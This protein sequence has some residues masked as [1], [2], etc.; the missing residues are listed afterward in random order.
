MSLELEI[1]R[2]QAFFWLFSTICQDPQ[3]VSVKKVHS[4]FT[5]RMTSVDFSK[6]WVHKI[7]TLLPIF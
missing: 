2:K 4:V 1:F 6:I 5:L 7:N 3:G